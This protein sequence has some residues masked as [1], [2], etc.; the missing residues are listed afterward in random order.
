MPARP[1]AYT[2]TGAQREFQMLHVEQGKGGQQPAKLQETRRTDTR[3]DP[4]IA[5]SLPGRWL[6]PVSLG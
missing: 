3:Q 5:E 1:S 2:R 6:R 4:N